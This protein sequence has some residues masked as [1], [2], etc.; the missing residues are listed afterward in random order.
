MSSRKNATILYKSICFFD[1]Q[2]SNKIKLLRIFRKM[3]L[4]KFQTVFGK[5]SLYHL[6]SNID[7]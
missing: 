7:E 6:L 4:S 3:Y 2:Y 5:L 1:I